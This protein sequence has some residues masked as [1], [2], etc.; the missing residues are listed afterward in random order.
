MLIDQSG[1]SLQLDDY[2]AETNEVRMVGLLQRSA[3][4]AERERRL[5]DPGDVLMFEFDL[6]TLLI[7]GFKKS[8]A[9]IVINGKT[10][11]HDRVAFLFEDNLKCF[12]IRVHSRDSRAKTSGC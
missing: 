9:L 5:R 3:A 12:G 4:I 1:K 7:N 11:A 2:F 6:Q 10:R 8:A